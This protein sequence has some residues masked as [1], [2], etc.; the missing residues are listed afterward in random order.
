MITVLTVTNTVLAE[1]K[2]LVVQIYIISL[3]LALFLCILK[4]I[5]YIMLYFTSQGS[6]SVQVNA[7]PL[8]YASTFLEETN[9]SSYP[10]NQVSRLK[11]VYRQVFIFLNMMHTCCM[12]SYS[13]HLELFS[14][15]IYVLMLS[16]TRMFID[17]RF[18]YYYNYVCVSIMY[19]KRSWIIINQGFVLN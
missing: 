14:F 3:S 5:I 4:K 18:I 6:I 2:Q 1:Q 19:T 17:L 7:G 9:C 13:L 8:A 12:Y 15:V 10:V 11:D 16:D